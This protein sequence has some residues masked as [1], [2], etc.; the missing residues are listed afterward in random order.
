M[1]PFGLQVNGLQAIRLGVARGDR[2]ILSGLDFTVGPGEVL[3]LVGSNG[4]GKT[5][6]LEVL[7]GL[8][9][10]CEG[11]LEG[12]PPVHALHWI[13]HR[14]GLHD[15]L[16]PLEN[17]HFW[18]RL[19]GVPHDSLGAALER[20]GMRRLRHRPCGRLSIGQ[21]RRAALARLL[22]VKRPWWFLDEPLAG[23]DVGGI[24]LLCRLVAAHVCDGGAVVLS[25]HQP[26]P[27][28]VPAQREL[29]LSP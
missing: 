9:A 15:A 13:G 1:L 17:L 2:Q 11:R 4:A 19:S 25:S 20:V 29:V 6:L 16:S 10:P 14:N 3:H 12:Q 23:L 22:V 8:R 18:C 24:D 27:D 28:S 21:R 5:S 26:L 7:C